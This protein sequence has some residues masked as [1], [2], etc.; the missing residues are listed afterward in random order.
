MDWHDDTARR[1]IPL[2][3]TVPRPF[4]SFKRRPVGVVTDALDVFRLPQDHS[5]GSPLALCLLPS[6]DISQ[7]HETSKADV[8]CSNAR[9]SFSSWEAPGRGV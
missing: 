4:F 5:I 2:A 9:P 8:L 3:P 7:D 1:E 6:L